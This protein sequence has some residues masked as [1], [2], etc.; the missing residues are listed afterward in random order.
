VRKSS[1]RDLRKI[2]LLD[3]N[4]F[5]EWPGGPSDKQERSTIFGC[6]TT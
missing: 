6:L 3:R 5:I 2:Y 1:Q 4:V